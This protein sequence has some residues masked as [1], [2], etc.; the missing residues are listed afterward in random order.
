M[1]YTLRLHKKFRHFANVKI[2]N[3][4]EVGHNIRFKGTLYKVVEVDRSEIVVVI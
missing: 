3:Q 2:K 4:V 1:I